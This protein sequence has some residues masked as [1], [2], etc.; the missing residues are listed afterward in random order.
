MSELR[1]RIVISTKNRNGT[2]LL[3]VFQAL[4]LVEICNTES[5]NIAIREFGART[6]ELA[7]IRQ[8]GDF[9]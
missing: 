6:H 7:G 4:L 8:F 1:P 3:G 9:S 5:V 2:G